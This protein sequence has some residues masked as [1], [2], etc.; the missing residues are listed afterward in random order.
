M[1]PRTDSAISDTVA[2]TLIIILV[3]ALA[4]VIAIIIM[5]VPL[6]PQQPTLA[7][8]KADTVMGSTTKNVP[9]IR[10]YQMAGASLTQEYTEGGHQVVNFTRVRLV[11]P[12][13][14][15]HKVQTAISMRGKTIEKGEPFYIFYYN[16]GGTESPWIWIT[17][18]PSRVFA[19]T[20]QP[21]SPH[22]TWKV[23]VTDEKDTN[24]VI[25]QQDIRL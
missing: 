17:N 15:S 10:L 7:A 18:D 12:T 9:V 23:L 21:F 16:T 3:V 14:K 6:L 5:G 8:F 20:V 25:F 4:A 11:D 19:S 24:M 1:Q 2:T 13:G 22:G